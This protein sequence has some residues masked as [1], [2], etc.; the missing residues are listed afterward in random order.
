MQTMRAELR[1]K[2][3]MG[4]EIIATDNQWHLWMF[5][6][7]AG[8]QALRGV[9]FTVLFGLPVTVADFF[10]LQRPDAVRARFD[11]SRRDHGM[12]E[13]HLSTRID[14]LQTARTLHPGRV[15]RVSA[16]QHHRGVLSLVLTTG[17]QACELPGPART[18]DFLTQGRQQRPQQLGREAIQNLTHLRVR[19]HRSDATEGCQVAAARRCGIL[20]W[21]SNSLGG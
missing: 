1:D 5:L 14:A 10:H 20:R 3:L 15:K 8:E 11:A 17:H 16:I 7:E 13:M 12:T 19:R 18:T 6:T 2:R 21:N 9:K 4:L